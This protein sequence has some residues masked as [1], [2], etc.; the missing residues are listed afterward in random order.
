MF[1]CVC[2][3]GRWSP[4]SWHYVRE[5]CPSELHPMSQN[6][7]LLGSQNWTLSPLDCILS[8]SL[9]QTAKRVSTITLPLKAGN[10]Q[11]FTQSESSLPCSQQPAA[12][13]Y[14]DPD[15]FRPRT[16]ILFI[17]KPYQ[18]YPF[19]YTL[20]FRMVSFLSFRS[21]YEHSLSSTSAVLQT[22]T[23]SAPMFF[24][25]FITHSLTHS[26]THSH[27]HTHIRT[28]IYKTYKTDK[29]IYNLYWLEQINE[30]KTLST[31]SC[32]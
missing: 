16:L 24:I 32:Q 3:G 11:H 23:Y 22:L 4:A 7:C 30:A 18:Y 25:V 12:L 19:V 6:H 21:G 10:C 27:T 15:Q 28:H 9:G 29:Y 8:V 20:V 17:Y 31:L 5:L 1:V 14:P 2:G 13:P 26:L